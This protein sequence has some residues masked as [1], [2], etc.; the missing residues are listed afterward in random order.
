MNSEAVL[1]HGDANVT[2][3]LEDPQHPG[4]FRFIDPDGAVGEKAY[5]MGMAMIVEQDGFADSPLEI[6]TAR[7]E[8]IP[9]HI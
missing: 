4:S 3:C 6:G 5:D 1:L 9:R 8:S 7:E 2:N